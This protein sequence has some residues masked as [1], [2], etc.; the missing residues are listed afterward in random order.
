MR[1]PHY[2]IICVVVISLVLVF[3]GS[4]N[5]P[6]KAHFEIV[7]KLLERFDHARVL[8]LP[9]GDD[10]DKPELIA[11]WHRRNMLERLFK[12]EDRVIVSNE[13]AESPYR[14]TL[15][16]LNRLSD[17]YD[18][19]RF[20]IGSDQLEGLTQ[21]INYQKLLE[22]YRF[23]VLTRKNALSEEETEKR[24]ADLKHD[25]TFIDFDVDISSTKIRRHQELRHLWLTKEVREYIEAYNLY[26][27]RNDNV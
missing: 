23:I 18:D 21:W 16:T 6:T 24:F 8:L 25:F 12:C 1:Q 22:R 3:G 17:T 19:I 13:E 2:G 4:F 20:V 10:Y 11:F 27:T 5:P 9:V 15:E 7:R 14:G 26:E